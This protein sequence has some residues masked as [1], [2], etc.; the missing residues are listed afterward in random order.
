MCVFIMMCK[1]GTPFDVASIMEEDIV[2]L[3][4]T[5]G[6]IHPLGVLQ[7]LAT[8]SVALSHTVE[9]MQQASC[10]A[11]KAMELHNKPIAIKIVAPTEP[12]IRAYITVGGLPL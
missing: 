10:G 9:E 5:L 11:I 4:M 2:Q 6:H 7:Y 8:E 1:D 12:H 3:C